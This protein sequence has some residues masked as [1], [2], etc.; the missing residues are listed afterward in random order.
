MQCEM[1]NYALAGVMLV[2]AF[3]ALTKKHQAMCVGFVFIA[4][5]FVN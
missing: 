3:T 4:M 5:F 1:F 2:L